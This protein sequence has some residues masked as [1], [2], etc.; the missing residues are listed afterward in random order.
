M[1]SEAV[2]SV[3]DSGNEALLLY[4]QHRAGRAP[5][6]DHPLGYGRELYFWSFVVALLIF[7]L[8]AGVSLYEGVRHVLQPEPIRQAHVNYIVLALAFLFEG[9]SWIVSFRQF[10]A[11]GPRMPLYQA[12][13]RS[14]DPPSFMVLLE[15]SAAL[16]GIVVAALG[17]FGSATLDMPALDGVASIVIGL[18]LAAVAILLAR[19]SKSLLIGEPAEKHLIEAIRQLATGVPGVVRANGALT[20]HL[21]PDQIVVSLSLEFDDGLRVPELEDAV[22]AIE[23]RVRARFPEVTA[24][25]IKPQSPA[26]F[27]DA[28]R[29]R[30]HAATRRSDPTEGQRA[31]SDVQV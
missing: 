7:A 3:V 8:G 25:F 31:D 17:T 23:Q 15:D 5:D 16:L 11:A 13:R 22:R 18:V 4:G 30:S 26:G 27:A 29:H 20:S 6:D 10:S 12:L 14:K 28:N 1:L 21:A 2:H 19:E 9:A 24:L